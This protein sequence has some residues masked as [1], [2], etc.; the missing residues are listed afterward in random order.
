MSPTGCPTYCGASCPAG[1]PSYIAIIC[2]P[3]AAPPAAAEAASRFL[4][5]CTLPTALTEMCASGQYCSYSVA[6]WLMIGANA[7]DPAIVSGP[8]AQAGAG[9][10]DP[11]PRRRP[12]EQPG[13]RH[14][15]GERHR[16]APAVRLVVEHGEPAADDRAEDLHA[17]LRRR[18]RRDVP[19]EQHEQLE[20]VTG[21][22]RQRGQVE[23]A[24]R[25]GRHRLRGAL[26]QE[27]VPSVTAGWP[28]S[29]RPAPL[30]S[31]A[32]DGGSPVASAPSSAG[33]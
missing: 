10:C 14:H 11:V 31:H 17:L 13:D 5:P 16:P 3:V 6:T 22:H 7:V 18:A 2:T 26:D 25:A 32:P 20:G 21:V 4:R 12:G 23:G 27:P 29:I 1:L 15:H 33:R 8:E 30:T 24:A 9:A 28:P 19:L